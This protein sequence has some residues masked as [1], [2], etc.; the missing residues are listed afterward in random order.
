MNAGNVWDFV[1]DGL[2]V[3]YLIALLAVVAGT[4][5]AFGA[6]LFGIFGS[7]VEDKLSTINASWAPDVKAVLSESAVLIRDTVTTSKLTFPIAQYIV[8]FVL[9][10]GAVLG[11]VA[12]AMTSIRYARAVPVAPA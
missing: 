6:L 9:F 7:T 5:N 8:M 2:F 10:L 3:N 12:L 1:V 4:T 11:I